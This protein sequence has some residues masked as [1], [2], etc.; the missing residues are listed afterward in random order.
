MSRF[1]LNIL[2]RNF[3]IQ[4][5]YIHTKCCGPLC[6]LHSSLLFHPVSNP[7]QLI[8]RLQHKLSFKLHFLEIRY[9]KL[10]LY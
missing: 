2:L 5:L 9:L 1:V 4:N 7:L 8:L 10:L 6:S 3:Q